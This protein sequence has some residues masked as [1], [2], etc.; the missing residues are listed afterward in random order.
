MAFLTQNHKFSIALTASNQVSTIV[1]T[2][3]VDEINIKCDYLKS[4][5]PIFVV[6]MSIPESSLNI[7]RDQ[8]LDLFLRIFR[9]I[10][11]ES[12]DEETGLEEMVADK[13]IFETTLQMFDNPVITKYTKQDEEETEES[14]EDSDNTAEQ[15]FKYQVSAIPT[16][17]LKFNNNIINDI[18]EDSTVSEALVS[19]LSN[20]FSGEIYLQEPTN[21]KKY[22]HII[23][24][25]MNFIPAIKYLQEYYSAYD[26]DINIFFDN[27]KMFIYDARNKEIDSE[28]TLTIEVKPKNDNSD[29]LNYTIPYID[30][31][32]NVLIYLSNEPVYS[33]TADFKNNMIGGT[34]IYNSYDDNYNLVSRSYSENDSEKVRVFWNSQRD[35]RYE[36]SNNNMIDRLTQITILNCDPTLF[37]PST[38]YKINSTLDYMDGEYRIVSKFIKFYNSSEKFLCSTNLS[39]VKI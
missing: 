28:N 23:I 35:S 4:V 27:K 25:P 37:Q 18:F 7:L 10:T 24:P 20:N 6:N 26:N 36:T 8:K 34:T 14:E 17:D 19:V 12:E 29:T 30:D 21:T 2:K 13:I 39:L 32:E 3:Y 9:N 1:L 22:N 11:E 5:Y 33:V 15:F 38:L 16:D 31:K